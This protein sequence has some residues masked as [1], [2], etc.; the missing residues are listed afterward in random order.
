M[1]PDQAQTGKH[2]IDAQITKAGWNLLDRNEVGFE[3]PASG[4]DENWADGF[5][6]FRTLPLN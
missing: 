6:D 3:V 5:T 2:I 4:E 1:F